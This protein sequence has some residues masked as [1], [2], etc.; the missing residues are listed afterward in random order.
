MYLA[1][2]GGAVLCVLLVL[3]VE[4]VDGVRHDVPGVHCLPGGSVGVIGVGPGTGQ[5]D[6]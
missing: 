5:G 3:R 1:R 4:V 2:I 6:K